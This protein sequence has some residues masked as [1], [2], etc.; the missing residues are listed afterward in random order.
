MQEKYPMTTKGAEALRAELDRLKAVERPRVINAIAEARAHGD[1]KENAEYHAAREEQGL[2]EAQIKDI[3]YKLSLAQIIDVTILPQNGK[4]VFGTTVV[5]ENLDDEKTMT[6]KIVGQDEANVN[7]GLLAYNT[8]IARALIG[9]EEGDVVE[10][11]TPSGTKSFEI[12]SVKY[13]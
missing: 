9:N 2:V 12:L 11:E 7:Q 6:Y 13:V 3:E 5:I 8:P 10:I 1:L 4:V